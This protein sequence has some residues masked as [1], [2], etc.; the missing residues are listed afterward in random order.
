MP[1]G[2]KRTSH[3]AKVKGKVYISLINYL[4]V[5]NCFLA[6]GIYAKV[7]LVH[8]ILGNLCIVPGVV[9]NRSITSQYLIYSA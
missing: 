6:N 8:N 1:E 5:Y 4:R 3:K 2:A 9:I 7:T